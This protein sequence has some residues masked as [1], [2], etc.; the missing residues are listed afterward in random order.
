MRGSRK[1]DAVRAVGGL[2]A[3][4]LMERFGIF[5]SWKDLEGL[6]RGMT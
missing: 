1:Q 4:G 6:S 3:G 5:L 2:A